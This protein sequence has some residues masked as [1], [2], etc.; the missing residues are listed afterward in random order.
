MDKPTKIVS[1]DKVTQ[2][3][4]ELL[5]EKHGFDM[6]IIKKQFDVVKEPTQKI[7]DFKV[8][9]ERQYAIK[10]LN[11]MSNLKQRERERVLQRALLLNKV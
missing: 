7:Y 10:V 5:I 9:H 11:I 2:K 1:K 4:V 3:E 6:E 8:E